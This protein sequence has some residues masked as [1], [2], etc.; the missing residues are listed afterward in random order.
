MRGFFLYVLLLFLIP[1]SSH[2]ITGKLY[3]HN[4]RSLLWSTDPNK[5]Y[6]NRF[7]IK[8][9]GNIFW[10]WLLAEQF[11]VKGGC[12]KVFLWD[13]LT[14]ILTIGY[15]P[16]A[17]HFHWGLSREKQS[18]QICF[19]DFSH[20]C[21]WHMQREKGWQGQR[22]SANPAIINLSESDTEKEKY[23]VHNSYSLL[24]GQH[25]KKC[26]RPLW[27]SYVFGTICFDDG[28]YFGVCHFENHFCSLLSHIF[29]HTS[30]IRKD[31][32]IDEL[33]LKIGQFE[34]RGPN[35]Q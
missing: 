19:S 9:T 14:V 15:S 16:Q 1:S 17:L 7:L 4:N 32:W 34:T 5:C 20:T 3:P 22:A 27:V 10:I 2:K 26:V 18:W 23:A 33:Y 8:K 35:E 28:C 12:F 13:R 24:K 29:I 11:T 31:N 25:R 21:R 6:Q 30:S